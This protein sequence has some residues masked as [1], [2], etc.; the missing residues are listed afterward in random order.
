MCVCVCVC[1]ASFPKRKRARG[2]TDVS[3]ARRRNVVYDCG[4][5]DVWRRGQ[6]ARR[7]VGC[8]QVHSCRPDPLHRRVRSLRADLYAAVEYPRSRAGGACVRS[9][10]GPP[11][12]RRPADSRAMA[13]QGRPSSL[14]YFRYFIYFSPLFVFVPQKSIIPFA[15]E[16]IYPA[17]CTFLIVRRS[18]FSRIFSEKLFAPPCGAIGYVWEWRNYLKSLEFKLPQ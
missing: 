14:F 10:S 13:G 15:L 3:L 18:Q 9:A 17:R 6:A 7:R 4:G 8:A 5:R 12:V 11:S 1:A 16:T 2:T